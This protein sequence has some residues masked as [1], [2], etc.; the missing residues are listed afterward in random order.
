MKL[1]FSNLTACSFI[2]KKLK[3]RTCF[4]ELSKSKII[5][6]LFVVDLHQ[7]KVHSFLVFRK[8]VIVSKLFH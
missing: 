4:K 6:G 5:L 1:K 8:K 3:D 2:I 7:Q